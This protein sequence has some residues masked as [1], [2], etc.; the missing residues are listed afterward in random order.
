MAIVILPMY[1]LI[2]QPGM[3]TC[4][5]GHGLLQKSLFTPRCDCKIHLY[6]VIHM[7]LLV[8]FFTP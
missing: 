4:I 7:A 1:L 6:T 8:L 2:S 3:S 5:Y